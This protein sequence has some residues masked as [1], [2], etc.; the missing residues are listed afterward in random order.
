MSRRAGFLPVFIVANRLGLSVGFLDH[1]RRA[2]FGPPFVRIGGELRYHW[3]SVVLW[4][5]RCGLTLAESRVP[6]AV[7]T[8]GAVAGFS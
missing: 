6:E 4:S 8:D 7:R 3:P 2:G 5:V 1:A